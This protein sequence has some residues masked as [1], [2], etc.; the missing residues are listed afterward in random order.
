MKMRKGF[1][2]VELLIVII[3]IG[4]LAT[5]MLLSSGANTAAAKAAT[6]IS[7]LRSMK[8]AAL[9]FY[10][11]SYDK[12]GTLV[13]T[14]NNI[15]HLTSFMDDWAKF[16]KNRPNVDF[17]T[18]GAGVWSVGI[19]VSET[20]VKEVLATKAETLGLYSNSTCTA[21]YTNANNVNTVYMKVR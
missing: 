10:T 2:L 18:W 4:I 9:M 16:L 12:V 19:P 5:A 13:S 3:I 11:A 20:R 1:T 7:D 21:T 6:I 14:T 8:A 15:N 17:R